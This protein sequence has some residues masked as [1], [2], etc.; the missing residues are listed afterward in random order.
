[1]AEIIAFRV[2]IKVMGFLV[3]PLTEFSHTEKMKTHFYLF[4]P[5]LASGWKWNW[6]AELNYSRVSYILLHTN[7]LMKVIN[8]VVSPQLWIKYQSRLMAASYMSESG[9][10]TT[11][12]RQPKTSTKINVYRIIVLTM[13]K[14]SDS[15]LAMG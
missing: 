6:N 1:M 15:L 4:C 13:H 11:S 5:F 12:K 10:T 3:I 7:A 14:S 9:K 2:R 8:P